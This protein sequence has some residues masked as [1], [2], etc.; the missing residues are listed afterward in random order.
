M[1]G[2]KAT[3]I[4][5]WVLSGLVG[6]LLLGPSAMGKF[7]DWEGKQ[8]MLTSMGMSADLLFKI[9]ILEVVVALLYLIPRTSFLGA[10]LLTGYLGGATLTHLRIGEPFVMPVLVG[11]VAWVAL[12]LRQPS[13]FSLV[14]GKNPAIP[15]NR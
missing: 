15:V 13:L 6:A 7:S 12:G 1:T 9:G 5:S 8:E 11:V 4:T 2:S 14:L 10:I 3:L